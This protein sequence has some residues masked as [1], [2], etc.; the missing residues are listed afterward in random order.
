M[1]DKIKL[2]G[3]IIFDPPDK[4]KKHIKQSSWKKIALVVFND[5][6]C[7]YYAWFLKKRFNL[8]ILHPVRAPHVTFINDSLRDINGGEGTEEFRNDLWRE[9][10][11][12]WDN[13][14][15][16]VVIDLNPRSDGE[17]WWFNVPEEYRIDLHNIRKEI[18]LGRPYYGLHLTIGNVHPKSIEHSEYILSLLKNNYA[19]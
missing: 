5:D 14:S 6:T 12:K 7:S 4:T 17:R 10:K 13:K 3:E 8:D 19:F 1:N 15:I 18:G 16:D 9:L 11:K 2:S